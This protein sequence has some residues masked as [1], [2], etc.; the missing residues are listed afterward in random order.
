MHRP[1]ST[2]STQPSRPLLFR[3]APAA[4]SAWVSAVLEPLVFVTV[5][6]LLAFIQSLLGPQW[7]GVAAPQS[8][9]AQGERTVPSPFQTIGDVDWGLLLL[10]LALTFPAPDHLFASRWLRWSTAAFNGVM[11]ALVLALCAWA[12]RGLLSMNLPLWASWLVAAPVV[13]QGLIAVVAAA[14]ARWLLRAQMP[15]AAVVGIGPMGLRTARA[16]R[17]LKGVQA[18]RFM[19]WFDLADGPSS[20]RG[21][22]GHGGARS[23]RLGGIRELESHLKHGLLD[24]LYL[25]TPSDERQGA[26]PQRQADLRMWRAIADSTVTVRWVPDVLKGTVVQGNIGTLDGLPLIG[27]TE[28][29]YGGIDGAAKRLSDLALA[30]MALLILSP[31]MLLIGIAVRLESA[32]PALFRQRRLGLNGRVIEVWK[33]RTMSVME[34]GRN[35]RQATRE[36][37]RVTRLGRFLRRTSLDE[38][39]QFINVLQGRMSVVGPRPH[40]LAHNEQYRGLVIA[41]MLRHK[42]RPGITG[43]A[44]VNG[45]RGETE[46]VEKMRRRVEHDL[47]YLQ[48]WSLSLDFQIVLRTVGLVFK[49]AKAW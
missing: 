29:P 4:G 6:L 13:H 24:E 19:G 33:F 1:D 9:Q 17:R 41:Y 18:R 23:R 42:V 31:L 32:G 15:N 28:S 40:A 46:T 37:T 27:L 38:L 5:F 35:V 20:R 21:G 11:L 39:P 10:V 25:T 30:S 34:D 44:Q 26:Q 2:A 43:W 7:G 45:F 47:F 12:T 14:W 48:N 8:A 22:V 3:P 36:D 16:L 49:D